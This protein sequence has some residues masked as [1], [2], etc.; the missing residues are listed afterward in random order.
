QRSVADFK[1]GWSWLLMKEPKNAQFYFLRVA[2]QK[3]TESFREDSVKA[4]AYLVSQNRNE[5]WIV[6]FA[7]KSLI[8]ESLRLV[9]L[10]AVIQNSYN[11]DKT[12]VPYRLFNELFKRTQA[13]QAKVKVLA[14]LITF[15]RREIATLG[16]KK[17]FDYLDS[18]VKKNTQLPWREFIKETSSLESD[19]RGYIQNFSDYYVG[20]VPNKVMKLE[21]NLVVETLHKQLFFFT[22]HLLTEE[23]KKPTINLWLDL[24][25]REQSLPMVNEV[26]EFLSQLNPPP[27]NEIERARLEKLAIVD[28]QTQKN[29]ELA[30]SLIVEIESFL[31]AYPASQEKSRLLNRLAELYMID[32]QYE[33][34]FPYLQ[35]LY[36]IQKTE[37]NAYN[38]IWSLF[39]MEKFSDV[40]SNPILESFARSPKITEVYR[41][42]HLKLAQAAQQ[43]GDDK[44]YQEN[45]KK[46][47][48]L[49][50]TQEQSN[51]VKANFMSGLLAKNDVTGYCLQR[52]KLNEVEK[53]N[54]LILDTEELGLD[55]M[56][57]L[58]PLMECHWS[59]KKGSPNREFKIILFEK[60][61][62]RKLSPAAEKALFNLN[63]DQQVL[64]FSL[65][66]M[67]EPQKMLQLN[68]PKNPS[69]AIKD[70]IWL[71]LQVSQAKM[72]PTVPPN[73]EPLVRSKLSGLS[74]LKN[75]SS[76]TKIVNEATF[77]TEKMQVEKFSKYLEDLIYR[78][79]LVKTKFQ[80]E[81]S[82]LAETTKKDVLELA[83]EFERKIA[84]SIR[85]SPVPE[86]FTKEE[87]D[88]YKA[89]LDKAAVDFEKQ[90]EEYDKALGDVKARIW[91]QEQE[92]QAE[93]VPEIKPE[94]WFWQGDEF[95]KI[96]QSYKD[97][98]A[99]YTLLK[100]ETSRGQQ[101][102]TEL[103]YARLRGGALLLIKNNDFM[104]SLIRRELVALNAFNLLDEWKALK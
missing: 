57:L 77:P 29:S 83:S 68:F 15:E 62:Q 18:L 88:N 98:G 7:K 59:K 8:D 30:K 19:L 21:K 35:Q 79:K 60:A 91:V 24:I 14:Q 47:L 51:V 32:S 70:M 80:K 64:L 74:Q 38:V 61:M 10:S 9:F 55:K 1:S 16:Q 49:N 58:G 46:F 96:S 3:Q 89:E 92:A 27:V 82:Q 28:G 12:K 84:Q 33:K 48:S 37:T 66:A 39:K 56:F 69:D 72:N 67:S 2:N 100:L 73:L 97:H 81:S 31:G 41:E 50:P 42:S 71:A 85:K 5:A 95:Q 103:D 54:K 53:N 93:K 87:L 76:I 101:V 11:I 22:R 63:Q 52:S 40:V 13:P 75:T 65:M 4:L 94:N 23:T 102:L 20:K 6:E 44:S 34:A 17:A 86:G 90:A 25:H 78:S 26:V 45:I 36:Q 43:S 104:R 99:F